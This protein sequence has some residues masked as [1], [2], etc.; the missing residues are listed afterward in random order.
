MVL[1]WQSELTFPD[2]IELQIPDESVVDDSG[3]GIDSTLLIFGGGAEEDQNFGL[4]LPHFDDGGF[5]R[6]QLV[7]LV[8]TVQLHALLEIV[9]LAADY[10]VETDVEFLFVPAMAPGVL[11]VGVDLAYLVGRIPYIAQPFKFNC[12]LG[13]FT[14]ALHLQGP[15][16]VGELES[17]VIVVSILVHAEEPSVAE[18]VEV[19]LATQVTDV[20]VLD[21][22]VCLGEEIE[23]D[24]VSIFWSEHYGGV[25]GRHAEGIC[26]VIEVVL[27]D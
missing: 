13:G 22:A 3:L 25:E 8:Q 12:W 18:V 21:N 5:H 2:S 6:T 1:G 16:V 15:G 24:Y 17:V 26:E 27:V 11:G 23:N 4:E 9:A 19:A 10:L 14:I 7:R 20:V